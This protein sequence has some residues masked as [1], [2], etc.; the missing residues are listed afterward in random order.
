MTPV[1]YPIGLVLDGKRVLLVGGGKI[2]AEK[3]EPLLRAGAEL[4]VVSPT[5]RSGIAALAAAGRITWHERTYQR[6]DLSGC[7]LVIAASDDRQVNA[8]VVTEARAAG[9]LT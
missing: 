6:E 2:A 4:T 9:I 3:V 7:A 1:C 8:R 5:A